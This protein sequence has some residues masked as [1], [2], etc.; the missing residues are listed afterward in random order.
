MT[1]VNND[2]ADFWS[3]LAPTWVELEDRLESVSGLPGLMAIDRLNLTGG[4][5]VIDLGCGTGQTTVELA[6][7]VAPDGEVLG[8]DIA[9]EMLARGRDRAASL[10]VRNVHFLR[11]DAQVHDFGQGRFDAAYSRFGVM[12]FA[13]PVAAFANVHKAL[14][15]G[16]LLSFVSWQGV[17][18]NEWMLIP[19]AAVA[20][21]TGSPPPIPEPG[22][23]GPF[24]M[25]DPERIRTVL[26]GGGFHHIEVTP[27]NDV[28]VMP[29]EQ[30]PDIARTSIR[31]GAAREALKDADDET[32]A[33]AV[34]AVEE[35]LTSRL[36]DGEARASRGFFLVMAHA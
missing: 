15:P 17:F 30:I 4:Q 31:I 21:V 24:S 22:E 23:P 5:R 14:P 25:A 33:R 18:D 35:A 26:S 34:A 11:A 10:G 27:H 3:Q 32:R 8:V 2:Q 13:D 6:T 16:G 1:F 9:D 28:I 29:R 7:R 19:G 20:S 12:F 36:Q